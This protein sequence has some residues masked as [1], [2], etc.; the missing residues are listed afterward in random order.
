MSARTWRTSPGTCSKSAGST[1]L[2]R[3]ASPASS[4]QPSSASWSS[5]WW[6]PSST[7]TRLWTPSPPCRC[8]P[9][10]RE[11]TEVF[12]GWGRF[13]YRFRWATLV[14]SG[15][16][17]GAS[18]TS[19]MLGGTLQTGGPLT[20]NLESFQ[21]YRAINSELGGGNVRAPTSTF[22]LIF[23][24][25]TMSVGDP[26][27]K[28]AVTTAMAPIQNDPRILSIKSPYNVPAQYATNLTSK[29][30]HEALVLVEIAKTMATAGRAITFSG[31]TAAVGISAM[32]FYQGTFMASMGAAGAM[33]IGIAVLYG[34][35]FLPALL[36]VMGPAVNRL[37][38]AALWRGARAADP[39]RG[40]WHGLAS[41]VMRRPIVVLVPTVAFLAITAIP[42][43]QLRM[44]NGD[45]DMLP[46][47]LEARQGYDRLIADFPGQDQTTLNIVVRYSD[48]SP[49]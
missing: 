16:L 22:D 2:R 4:G 11:E 31:L 47:R 5:R 6:I 25:D 43:T 21:A 33:V 32:L 49:L 1:R 13:V 40:F 9:S 34:L 41:W 35:T 14:A 8:R 36:S 45:V 48:G 24:S 7:P 30:G 42:F 28:D 39:D 12:A 18:L 46:P 37:R 26:A 10:I 23:K 27:Y 17:L 20:S 19:L 3:G 44:A 38:I 15:L 29:D